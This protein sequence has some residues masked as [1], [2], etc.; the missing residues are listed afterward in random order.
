MGWADDRDDDS[1]EADYAGFDTSA[2]DDDATA[3]CPHCGA[4]IY[5]DAE[6]CPEC[7]GYVS[8][9][10]AP[11]ARRPL[12]VIVGAVICLVIALGWI[13]GGC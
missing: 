12:W 9:E 4:E 11:P 1:H 3:P 5:D 6:R 10:E 2:P 13:V 7:G 8:R